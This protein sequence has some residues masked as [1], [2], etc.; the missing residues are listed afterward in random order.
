MQAV[1]R[2]KRPASTPTMSKE[3][4]QTP[5]QRRPG[6]SVGYDGPPNAIFVS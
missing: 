6:G 2:W 1:L 4:A 3:R 5:A